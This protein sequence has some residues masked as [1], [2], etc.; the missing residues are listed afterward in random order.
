MRGSNLTG[1]NESGGSEDNSK[2]EARLSVHVVFSGLL[3]FTGLFITLTNGYL[4]WLFTGP[5]L[6]DLVT[7]AVIIAI[8]FTCG[9][10][11]IV[12][13]FGLFKLKTWA[14]TM[15]TWV[16]FIV[17]LMYATLIVNVYAFGAGSGTD[18][19]SLFAGLS[20]V[21]LMGPILI[22]LTILLY[23]FT[24]EAEDAFAAEQ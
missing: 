2:G 14:R 1:V 4:L 12:G 15:L 10:L 22:H 8:L 23:F 7:F 24:K 9:T 17:L 6:Q 19:A 18:L 20:I 5:L 11:E 13:S 21:V 16:V 3:F